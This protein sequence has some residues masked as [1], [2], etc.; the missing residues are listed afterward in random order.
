MPFGNFVRA[1][2]VNDQEREDLN[3]CVIEGAEVFDIL[4]PVS[5]L[6]GHREN[7]LSL[8]SKVLT[9]DKS[10]ALQLALQEIPSETPEGTKLSDNDY[11]DMLIP[12]LSSGSPSEDAMIRD[13]LMSMID[14]IRPDSVAKE[15]VIDFKPED[16]PAGESK[17]E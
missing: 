14:V 2:I 1:G 7:P 5:K 3:P 16:V 15:G 11:L 10:R 6:T 8:M 12:R 9:P 13:R 17:S 4:C